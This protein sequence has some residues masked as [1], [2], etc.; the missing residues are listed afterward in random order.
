MSERTITIRAD[1]YERLV[2]LAEQLPA[3]LDRAREAREREIAL[4]REL[5]TL[6]QLATW[7]VDGDP[8]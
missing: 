6:R 5:D 3:A 7:P 2:K 4:L 8:Q 1:T